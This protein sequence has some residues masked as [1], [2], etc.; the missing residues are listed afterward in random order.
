VR[1]MPAAATLRGVIVGHEST[2]LP[3]TR[4]AIL[5]V[6]DE[7]LRRRGVA[8]EDVTPHPLKA[9]MFVLLTPDTPKV[10]LW[11]RQGYPFRTALWRAVAGLG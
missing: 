6:V 7:E 9:G 10:G 3:H 1:G 11:L 5:A 2:F 8:S 4:Q